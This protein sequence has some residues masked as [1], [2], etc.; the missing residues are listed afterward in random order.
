MQLIYFKVTFSNPCTAG[1]LQT[2]TGETAPTDVDYV[3]EADGS[4]SLQ[5]INSKAENTVGGGCNYHIFSKIE[6]KKDGQWTEA[7]TEQNAATTTRTSEQ[8]NDWM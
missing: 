7:W 1:S 2:K 8:W 3:V 5:T 6:V 4:T